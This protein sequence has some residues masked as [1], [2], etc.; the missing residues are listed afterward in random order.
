MWVLAVSI[1]ILMVIPVFAVGSTQGT[2]SPSS[3]PTTVSVAPSPTFPTPIQHVFV[4]YMENI[5]YGQAEKLLNFERDLG[6]TYST[7]SAFYALCHPSAANYIAAVAGSVF[8]QC[9]SDSLHKGA[10]NSINIADLTQAVGETWNGFDE[11]MPHPCDTS[12]ATNYAASANPFLYFP[13]I[14]NNKTRCD[15]YDVPFTNW[16]ADVNASATDPSAIPNYAFFTPNLM[17]NGHN[18]NHV[19][20]DAW[21]STF[22]NTWFL[23]RSFMKNSVL[24]ITYDEGTLN[25]GYT[26]GNVTTV[27]GQIP[28]YV[29]SPY[30]VGFHT[31]PNNPFTIDSTQYN[32]LSTTE[33]LLGLGSTGNHDGT[34]YFPA[35]KGLFNF[36]DTQTFPVPPAYQWTNLTSESPTAPSARAQAAEVYDPADGYILLF[37]GHN[38][39]PTGQ[40][41]DTWTYQ[42]GI[43]TQL[44]PSTHPTARRG[45][46]ITYDTDC[47]CAVLYGGTH[48]TTYLNDTWTYKA[49]VWTNIT[50]TLGPSGVPQIRSAG[51]AF[52]AVNNEIVL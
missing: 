4:L 45:A 29:I 48:G 9:R 2:I 41:S 43:W 27:G 14:V 22:V 17:D 50:G 12:N 36:N 24:F 18:E 8:T 15:D 30:T 37:G 1:G 32:L 44:H 28:F 46:M 25:N 19:T 31:L 39:S 20:A 3:A 52:D 16:Y 40:F 23:N 5:Q 51:M 47:G 38:A 49:G 34:S 10:Y 21:L 7:S 26:A 42:N 35:M 33:W 6:N 11:S 13:D